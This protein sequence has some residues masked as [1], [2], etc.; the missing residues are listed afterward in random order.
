MPRVFL[1]GAGC[2]RNYTEGYHSH[3]MQSPLDHD[4]FKIAKKI[5]LQGEIEAYSAIQFQKVVNDLH[6]LYGY[7]QGNTLREW[8]NTSDASEYLKVFDDDRLSL[9]KV[10]TQLSL[11]SQIFDRT[12]RMFGYP[13]NEVRSDDSLAALV[14]LIAMT[15]YE[16]LKGPPCSKHVRLA[17]TLGSEDTVLSFNYD[18]LIDNALSTCN[19]LTDKGYSMNFQKS[20]EIQDWTLP[21]AKSSE[22]TLLKLHGSMNWLHCSICDGYL[23]TRSEKVG[24]WNISMPPICPNCQEPGKFLERVIVPPL[25]AKDYTAQPLKNLWNQALGKVRLADEM[26]IIG[27]SFPPT[28]FA[29]ELLLRSGLHWNIQHEVHFTIVNPDKTVYDRFK[30]AFPS[31]EVDWVES[32]DSYLATIEQ[33]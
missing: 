21:D 1:I 13:R 2:S 27:Y 14:E 33:V 10:M 25:L 29:A 17:K 6:R 19:K 9:E 31:S 22:V 32:L 23:L 18:L 11:E 12:P 28:D 26:T 16:A 7:N 5:L 15:I 8:L 20:L 24:P 30:N 3:E 4:F